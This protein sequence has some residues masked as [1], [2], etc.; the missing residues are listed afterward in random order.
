[1]TTLCLCVCV[2]VCVHA[3]VCVCVLERLQGDFVLLIHSLCKILLTSTLNGIHIPLV[4]LA[5]VL[6]LCL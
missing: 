2:Y 5:I 3:C 4:L 6:V 1:M